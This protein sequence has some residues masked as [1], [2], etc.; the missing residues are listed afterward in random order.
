MTKYPSREQV[1]ATVLKIIEPDYTDV[2]FHKAMG[3]W[4]QNIRTSGGYGLTVAGAKAFENAQISY[5]EFEAAASPLSVVFAMELD[6]KMLVP[7][8]RYN[9]KGTQRV[10]IYDGRVSMIIV[11]YESIDTYL[12]GLSPRSKSS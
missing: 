4:W 3:L 9:N 2:D 11:L 8:H 12:E 1:T 6:K 7:Y 5:Q 10:K